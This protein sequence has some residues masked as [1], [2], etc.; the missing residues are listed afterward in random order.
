MSLA[1]LKNVPQ[2]RVVNRLLDDVRP[3]LA[4]YRRTWWETYGTTCLANQW[5][6]TREIGR[7]KLLAKPEAEARQ[8]DAASYD[9]MTERARIRFRDGTMTEVSAPR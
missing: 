7:V 8:V 6:S 5:A 9:P 1:P 3:Y 2:Q 4:D